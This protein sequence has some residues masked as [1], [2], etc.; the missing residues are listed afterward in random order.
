[1]RSSRSVQLLL[2]TLLGVTV[3]S[4]CAHPTRGGQ[5]SE[6]TSE[7]KLLVLES[8]FA[9]FVAVRLDRDE[10]VGRASPVQMMATVERSTS[11]LESLRLRYLEGLAFPRVAER[12]GVPERT[13]RSRV[14]RGL[15]TLRERMRGES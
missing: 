13:A 11:R 14:A 1:M 7:R 4:G 2:V 6:Q 12:L 15:A 3:A 8:E 9:D 10:D 5:V